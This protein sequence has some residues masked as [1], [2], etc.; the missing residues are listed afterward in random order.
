MITFYKTIKMYQM[1][2]DNKTVWPGEISLAWT[3]GVNILSCWWN[4]CRY[5]NFAAD[6]FILAIT[7][8]NTCK[9]QLTRNLCKWGDSDRIIGVCN[10]SAIHRHWELYSIQ[11]EE[12]AVWVN[13]LTTDYDWYSNISLSLMYISCY[14]HVSC[15][16]TCMYVCMCRQSMHHS[17]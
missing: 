9:P 1:L 15:H 17:V 7:M 13:L 5:H 16:M 6:Y 10:F 2:P 11:E 8:C 3:W 12:I 14:I 4:V